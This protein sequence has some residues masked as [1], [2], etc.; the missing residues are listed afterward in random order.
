MQGGMPAVDP[1]SGQNSG[2]AKSA[3]EQFLCGSQPRPLAAGGQNST[4]AMLQGAIKGQYQ[5]SKR[6]MSQGVPGM[7]L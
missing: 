5:M 1:S 4:A 6:L 3:N 2:T 7:Q